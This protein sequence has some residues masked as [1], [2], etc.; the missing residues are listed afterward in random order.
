M[1]LAA[2]LLVLANASAGAVDK[3]FIR[4]DLADAVIKLE[5]QIKTDTGTVTKSAPQLRRDADAA[6][7]KNDLRGAMQIL[8][9]LVVAVPDDASNWLRLSRAILQVKPTDDREKTALLERAAAAAYAAYQRTT[10]RGEEADALVILG[11][12]FSD[13]KVWR[14]ALDALR[15]SLDLREVA[16]VRANYESLRADHG[17]RLLDYSVD[18]DSASPRACFQFSEVLPGRRTDFSPFVSVSGQD[19]PAISA[20]DKQLCVEGLKHGERYAITLRAG[21]PST[22]R[23]TLPRSA[24]FNIYVRDR[25]PFVRFTGKAYVL[26]KTGQRGIPVVSVNT[27]VVKV[28]VYR[29]GDRSLLD[30]V[31]GYSFQ[32][33]ISRYE[34]DRLGSEKGVE[35]WKGELVVEPK[36]NAEVITAFPIDKTVGD[37]VPGIYVM[38]AQP[39]GPTDRDY[40]P[41]AT[42]WFVVSDLGITAYSGGDGIRVNVN[43]LATATPKSGVELRLV[44]RNNEVLATKKTDTDGTAVFEPGLSRGEGGMAPSLLVASEPKGDYAFLNLAGPAFDLSDRGVSGREAPTGP[45]AFVIT[46]RGVYRTGETVHITAL[47]R[48][49]Q[50]AAAAGVPLTI[51]VERPDGVEY[52]RAVVADQ[53][54]GGRNLDV[55]ITPSSSTGTWRVR[56]YTDPK[57]PAVGETTFMVEDYVP[58]RL[59]FDIASKAISITKGTPIKVTIDGHYLYG[60]PAAELELEGEVNVSEADGRPGFPGYQ[61]GSAPESKARHD[62][63]DD[64]EQADSDGENKVQQSLEDVPATDAAGKASFDVTLDKVPD[65][66]RP[67]EAEITIRMAESG[68]RAVERSLTL[69]VT[70]SAPQIGVKPLFSGRSLGEGQ[71]ASFDVV[72]VAPD[73]KTMS[74]KGLRYELL[75]IESQYQWYRTDSNWRFEPVKKTMRIADGTVDVAGDQAGRI[76]L[77]VNWGRYRLEVSTPDGDILTTVGFDAGFY[78]EAGSDT[79]DLL[80]TALDKSEYASGDTMTV[81][82]TARTAGKLTVNAFGDRLL[83]T[84]AADVKPGLNKVTLHVGRD[85]GNGGYVVAT[86]RRPLDEK[87]QRMPDRAIGL[88]YFSVDKKARTLALDMTL[89]SLS[90]PNTT[91]TVPIKVNGLASGEE[92]RVV[93]AAVDVGILNL[94]GYK[95][96]QPEEYYLGQRSLSTEIRDL[97]GQLIDGMQGTV[98]QVRTGGDSAGASLTGSPPTQPPVTLYSG[99]VAVDRNGNAEV[100]FDIPEFA[101]TVRVMAIAWSKDKVGHASG[102][103][104]VR[105]P[106][107]VTTTLPRFMLNGDRSTMQIDIDNVEGPAGDYRLTVLP[108]GPVRVADAKPQTVKLAAKQKSSLSVP[109]TS[110]G[111][112]QASLKVTI[113]E[114]NGFALD[115][116][117]QLA[118]KPATQILTRRTVKP[119]AK[120]ESLTVSAD[121]IG[122]LVPGTGNV[123]LSIGPSAALD[124][125]TLLKALDRYPFGCSEQ[126]TSRA[127]PLLYVNELAAE[128]HLAL[129]TAIDQRIRDAIERL[130]TRQ[131]SNGSFGLWSVGG[132]DI[133]LDSYVT[134]FLTRAKEKGFAV[135]DSAFKL[136]LDRLRNYV[137]NAPETN[138]D[139]GHDLAYALYVLARNGSAPIGDLRYIA[140]TKLD[141]IDTPMA[142]AQIAAALALVGDRVRAER[143]YAAAL[144]KLVPPTSFEFARPDYGSTLRDGAAFVALASEGGAPQATIFNAVQRVETARGASFY[145]STQENAWMVLAAR[146]LGKEA[147]VAM[148][149]AGEGRSTPLYRNFK[150]TDLV[151]PVKVDNTGDATLQAVISV[152]GAPLVPE[153]AAEKGFKIERSYYTLAGEKTD[154]SK[155]KQNTRMAVVLT[156]TEPQPRYGRV[157]VAD[158]LPAGFEIDN[159][160]LVSSGD[161]GT[162]SWIENAQEPVASEFRDDRFSAAFDRS[163]S[164]KATFTVAYVVRAVSPGKYVLPQAMV[165]DMYRPDRFGRTATGTVEVTKAK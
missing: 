89:P 33:N 108:E 18:A 2:V 135:P 103:V 21:L 140:D 66:T 17:F 9:A 102:D 5:A 42:Q 78:A 134:E 109:L 23:E 128:A 19:K 80:E 67:L 12:S 152:T 20:D 150:A 162:L 34:L 149:V 101:G 165:E 14:P 75:R 4:D 30:T 136:A 137:V 71:N 124:A 117:Y 28:Q 57:R 74:R 151:T 84:T 37:L 55:A 123:A 27:P 79:P 127:M 81:A 64:E 50:G 144:S 49:A 113:E 143:A 142:R 68:G 131:G 120:G 114:P 126:I 54:L 92:A 100:R 147:K 90:R 112:G 138:K 93:V 107:V 87:E 24:D 13:R 94:T 155:V 97:Y 145:T 160:H 132:D 76:S 95:P 129:D 118:A 46:E 11:R 69:P 61:F 59:E 22:V 85:W 1:V 44:A 25:K 7:A 96:P 154:P 47:L 45:D 51:V 62:D 106:V 77:P 52:R 104:T 88:Q 161:T 86:L 26:P 16:D 157:M 105:D 158:Y 153:P 163:S 99:L 133:W 63:D 43:S 148:N 146:A 122:D 53:G 116:N 48:D 70:P 130:L 82:V 119:I 8:G 40:E 56:A 65:T 139:G 38:S 41:L 156:I 111:A 115:R 73:G 83:A 60:A 72:M 159:P 6:F 164:D 141:D 110:V 121:L 98:G 10:V 125:A 91:L 32:R 58:D 15:L 31:S 29:I 36:L 39:S 35:V 3:A